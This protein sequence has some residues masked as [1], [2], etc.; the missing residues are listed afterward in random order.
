M[1][2]G[3][4]RARLGGACVAVAVAGA[5]YQLSLLG[6]IFA[7]T[8]RYPFDIEWMESTFLYQAYRTMRGLPTY[9][10][11]RDGFLPLNHPPAYTAAMGLL[12]RIVGLD[13]GMG[14]TVSLLCFL[15]SAALVVRALVRHAGGRMEG[16]ALAALA[17]GC[18]AAGVPVIETSTRWSAKT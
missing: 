18:A 13:Y 5:V 15:A 8:V 10:S 11:P 17:V 4:W 2:R 9:G 3:G 12:G 16:W 7:G 14:R 1:V 6:R